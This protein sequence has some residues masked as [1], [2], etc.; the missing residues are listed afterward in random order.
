MINATLALYAYA[1]LEPRSDG[2]VLLEAT[3]LGQRYEGPAETTLPL[4]PE[5]LLHRGVYNR[6]VSTFNRGR[7]LPVT[8]RTT[9]DV[10]AGSGLGG[11]SSLVV[12]ILEAFRNYLNLPFG[13]YDLA[14]LA[15]EI[16]RED[17]EIAGG[18]QDQYAAAFGGFNFIE[19]HE[20]GRAV[21][22]PLRL[23][24]AAIN[25]LEASLILYD[26]GQSR[27][28]KTI[29][30]AQQARIVSDDDALR[31]MFAL[32]R[33]A[34]EMKEA[35]ITGHLS[36]CAETINR[37]WAAKKATA[38]AVSNAEIERVLHLAMQSGALAG[39]V[40]GAGGGGIL[41]ILC[42]PA[43]RQKTVEILSREPGRLLPCKFT[44]EGVTSW[45]VPLNRP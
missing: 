20:H 45:S 2:R 37:G 23:R 31:A 25:E 17:L 12:A 9:V 41:M 28:S 5:A 40:S 36:D 1:H 26:T 18:K 32:K 21:V 34:L 27:H 39:K 33:E 6:I 19:F 14:R 10:P 4:G 22:N 42:D 13:E 35:L 8:V 11:S 3:E 7:P 29:I 44:K 24:S 16:E 15:F 30:E 38:G 43:E